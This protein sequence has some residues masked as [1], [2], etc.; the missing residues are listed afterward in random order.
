[1]SKKS[2]KKDRSTDSIFNMFGI[3]V[4]K[5]TVRG[6][7]SKPQPN[8]ARRLLHVVGG[9]VT[10]GVVV[11]G[12]YLLFGREK[13]PVPAP[14]PNPAAATMAAGAK[15][16]VTTPKGQ[17][18]AL[19]ASAGKASAMVALLP[20]GTTVTVSGPAVTV[21]GYRWY[22]VTSPKGSGFMHSDILQAAT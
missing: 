1:M 22:P 20:K 12:A 5:G 11:G 9:V 14:A 6:A 19:R 4:D 7:E 16:V 15:L 3:D 10:A 8:K 18:G 13:A 17:P 2:K 21:S